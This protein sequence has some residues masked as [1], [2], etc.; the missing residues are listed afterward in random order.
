MLDQLDARVAVSSPL[1]A[2]VATTGGVQVSAERDISATAALTSAA[3]LTQSELVTVTMPITSGVAVTE[4]VPA[5]A[6]PLA[7]PGRGLGGLVPTPTPRPQ[8]ELTAAAPTPD[9]TVR[10][11]NVPIL[12]YHYLSVPPTWFGHLPSR[13]SPLRPISLLHN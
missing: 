1:T 2:S 7:T 5:P 3:V 4:T 13:I 11:V 8:E 12:M 9:G 10:T 6:S